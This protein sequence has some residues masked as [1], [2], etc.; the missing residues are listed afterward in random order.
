[1]GLALFLSIVANIVL[2]VWVI[3][4][5]GERNTS[6]ALF[7]E[8]HAAAAKLQ[9][10][11]G[12]LAGKAGYEIYYALA[13]V[14]LAG[15]S[16]LCAQEVGTPPED[17]GRCH[18]T[19]ITHDTPHPHEQLLIDNF[20]RD[21]NLVAVRKQCLFHHYHASHALVKQ[22]FPTLAVSSRLPAVMLQRADGGVLFLASGGNV[23]TSAVELYDQMKHYAGLATKRVGT[24]IDSLQRYGAIS[25]PRC[26]PGGP[27]P[28]DGRCPPGGPC[29]PDQYPNPG[30]D[31]PF[32]PSYN[33]ADGGGY[34][35]DST[36][37]IQPRT[38]REAQNTAIVLGTVLGVL[39]ILFAFCAG[40]A[41]VIGV[42]AYL[43]RPR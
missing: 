1:M 34:M 39:F 13:I 26:P 37:M 29:P 4:L 16:S 33:P 9:K 23:P 21:P 17:G 30:Y 22:R 40:V 3:V 19:I 6:Q 7:E 28:P 11:I 25:Y 18:L 2:G 41:C 36:E 5:R 32:S 35:P 38:T 12:E 43:V 10:A 24:E 15:C 14:F 20:N 31:L 8:R 42:I 27:C